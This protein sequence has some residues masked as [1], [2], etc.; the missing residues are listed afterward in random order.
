MVLLDFE[1]P[2]HD[3]ESKIKELRHLSSDGKVDIAREVSRLEAK[4]SRLLHQVYSQLTPWQKVMVARHPER[5]KL[6]DY[7]NG[8]L[9][10]F[11]PLKGDRHFGEDPAITGGLAYFRGQSVMVMGHEKGWDTESRVHHNFG[12]PKPEGYRKAVRLMQL[13]ERFRLPVITFIDT[14]GAHPGIEAEER[15]QAEAIARSIETM[16]NLNQP[17]VAV[18]T[19]EGGSGGAI[20]LGVANEIYMLEHAIYS[21]ISPE[22][23]ASILWRTADKKEEAALAQ[24]LTA[25]DLLGLNLIDGIIAEPLGGAHRSAHSV[26]KSVGD[27]IEKSLFK[28]GTNTHLRRTRQ[29][30]FMRMGALEG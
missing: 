16:L 24:K 4:L 18:V 11:I 25:Q 26:I 27:V 21:V 12:M 9:E 20:A 22:G 7:I 14:A 28:Q 5:P 15:G 23:C 29:E 3:L 1:Q 30:K 8:L 19:G 2:I 6:K 10:E 17:T 13:A